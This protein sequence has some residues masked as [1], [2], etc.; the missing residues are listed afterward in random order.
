MN[1]FKV[2]DI[3]TCVDALVTSRH[4]ITKGK[5]Y[6]VLEGSQVGW[7]QI[8]DDNERVASWLSDRFTKEDPKKPV[9]AI[10]LHRSPSGKLCPDGYPEEYST[11]EAAEEE[12]R[13]RAQLNPKVQGYIVYVPVYVARGHVEIMGENL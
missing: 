3:V 8:R 5:K 10:V 7:V 1:S 4:G 11:R 6:R 12:A 2:G 13:K 9:N